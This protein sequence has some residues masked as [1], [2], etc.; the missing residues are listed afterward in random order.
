MM[1]LFHTLAWLGI[2]LL[3][4]AGPAAAQGQPD[5]PPLTADAPEPVSAPAPPAA[6]AATAPLDKPEGS[7]EVDA[8]RKDY[9]ELAEAYTALSK[10]YEETIKTYMT[11]EIQALLDAANR[12]RQEMVGQIQEIE[13]KRRKEAIATMESFVGRYFRYASDP[14]Y[15]EHIADALFKLAELYRDQAEYT[16][17]L[18]GRLRDQRM[19]EYEDG[20]RPSPPREAEA[21]Y[22]KALDAYARVMTEFPEYRYRDMVMYLLGYY[23]RVSERVEDSSKVLEEMVAAYPASDY[24]MAAWML[25]GHNNYDLS[26]YPKAI[27]AY[28]T[29][30]ERK[31]NNENYEDALYRLG[32]SCFEVF[33]YEQ[34]ISA[35]LSLLDYGEDQKGKKK[36]R[37]ALRREAIESIANSFVDADW[38]GNDLPDPDYG[39][40]RAL[41]YISRNKSYEKEILRLYGDLLFDLRDAEHYKH[42]VQAYGA[43]LNRFPDDPE[44]PLVH[45]RI[46]YCYF[47]L[48]RT[49]T[50]PEAERAQYEEL[51]MQER[52]RMVGL[53]G[54]DSRWAELH[55]YNAKALE[56]ASS[57]LSVNLLEQAQ[58]VHQHAQE[59]KDES[60]A[61]A[62]APYYEQ[63][64]NA[65][66][67]FLAEFPNHPQYVEMLRR[68]ADVEMFGRSD[69]VEAA[70]VFSQLRDLDRKDNPYREE[71]ASLVIE[72]RAKLVEAAA[73]SANAGTPIPEKLFDM[74]T[75]T[76]LATIEVSDAKDPTK[77]RKVTPVE[78]PQ[79]VV[80]WMADAQKYVDMEFPGE[81]NREYS[82][83]LAFQ[84]GKIYLRYG[85]FGPARE[86][87]EKVLAK[88]GDHSL[89]SVYCF[90]DMAR[91][92]RLEND[93]DN[94]EIVSNRMKE[95]GKG[96]AESV[97]EILASIK[98]AR[99]QARFQRA[100]ELLEQAKAATANKEVKLA[101][102][103]HSKTATEL[104]QIVD[105]NPTFDKADVALLEAARSYEEVQLYDKAATL[106][107]RLVD[108]S[109]FEKSEY[110][111]MAVWNL[112]ENYEKFFAFSSAVKT[113]LKIV[114]DYPKSA[115]VKKSM[116]LAAALYENDQEYLEAAE[117][118]EDFLKRFPNE[119]TSA[120]LAYSL[121]DLYE[122]GQD[123]AR[124]ERALSSFLKKHGKDPKMVVQAMTATIKLGRAAEE[125]G[126]KKDAQQY[127][128]NVVKLYEESGQKPATRPATLCAEAAFRLAESRFDEYSTI[129]LGTSSS[130]QRKQ[131]VLKRD[132]LMELEKIYATITNYESA[133]WMVAALY[134]AG[135]LWKD[136]AE[137]FATAPY[138]SDLPQDEDFKYQY[139]IQIG[140]LRAKFEDTARSRWRD[141]ADIAQKTGVYDEWTYKTLVELN[142]F[143]EDRQRYPL[144][145]EVKQFTSQEPLLLFGAP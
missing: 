58:L 3:L 2:G 50:L 49:T 28:R 85:H 63:A 136:L 68:Y 21:D 26:N 102:E 144:F 42:G 132:K 22:S 89:L 35:F 125:A 71:S 24:A 14:Q 127:F 45:D 64:A 120:K 75:G 39:P 53:Y 57:K 16:M 123:K 33:K 67:M 20:I 73:A 122:K 47:E 99:L 97:N 105:E 46:V 7:G 98:D 62:A 9:N 19:R 119:E 113:Y 32:W 76:T 131:G 36:Q 27:Q 4:A 107:R 59:V 145:R 128:K 142:R 52:N 70:K 124:T 87:Y 121:I 133:E 1:R 94:L 130:Q 11:E 92:Y 38:D 12:T 60:G 101:R 137:V 100:A 84:I 106:Y 115:N 134:K 141:A 103:L 65:Y 138:P 41:R 114:S 117:L 51:A 81:K 93:L 43:Y 90:T 44:N 23:L 118:I 140:D 139:E 15:R 56:L 80:N 116:L 37:I 72:A 77:P 13:A 104:E 135:A 69:F 112:A 78:I 109:R 29:V 91:T 6:P 17:E 88:W 86:Q 83:T 10:D 110:R 129:R 48:S 79:V 95:Q 40:G 8:F 143:E 25:V 5:E 66:R 61:A 111:E 31:E 55:K 82:G 18:D 108:E 96:D 34:A 74:S 30:V 126:R 54:K